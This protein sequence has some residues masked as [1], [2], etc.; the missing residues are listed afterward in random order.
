MNVHG[1]VLYWAYTKSKSYK[2]L[3][4]ALQA[5]KERYLKHD[6]AGPLWWYADNPKEVKNML[7]TGKVSLSILGTNIN[8]VGT[9]LSSATNAM[10]SA[11][12]DGYMHLDYNGQSKDLWIEKNEKF[13]LKN[14]IA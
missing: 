5:L 8:D 1:Q 10:A 2:E 6:K 9:A 4:P 3:A 14:I 11:N 12:M 13:E 7:M